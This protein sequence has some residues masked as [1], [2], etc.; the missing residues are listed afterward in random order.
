MAIDEQQPFSDLVRQRESPKPKHN[1]ETRAHGG[2]SY[3]AF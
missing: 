2:G 1:Y 3:K